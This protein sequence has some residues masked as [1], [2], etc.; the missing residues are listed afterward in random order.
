M[1]N[2]KLYKLLIFVIVFAIQNIANASTRTSLE[3]AMYEK[4]LLVAVDVS[5]YNGDNLEVGRYKAEVRYKGDGVSEIFDIL[6]SDK[7]LSINTCIAII[8]DV[9]SES[10]KSNVKDKFNHYAIGG[11]QNTPFVINLTKGQYIHIVP[12]TYY[13]IKRNL[14]NSKSVSGIFSLSKI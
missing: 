9:Y 8:R 10:Y 14:S 13:S 4:P 7:E 12:N 1:K 6:V 5:N 2:E 3:W 11:F